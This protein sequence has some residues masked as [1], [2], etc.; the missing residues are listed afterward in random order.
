MQNRSV[1]FASKGWDKGMIAR[2]NHSIIIKAQGKFEG[3]WNCSE[4]SFW[5]LLSEFYRY[6]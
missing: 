6:I 3:R 2:F 5:W 1:V 4:H